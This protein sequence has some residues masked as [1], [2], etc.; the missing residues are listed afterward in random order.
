MWIKS[1]QDTLKFCTMSTWR[2]AV[3]SLFFLQVSLP[4]LAGLL[5]LLDTLPP[6]PICWIG[7]GSRGCWCREFTMPSKNT[8]QGAKTWSLCGDSSGV[9]ITVNSFVYASIYFS[10]SASNCKNVKN[11]NLMLFQL[12][13]YI[14]ASIDRLISNI[15]MPSVSLPLFSHIFNTHLF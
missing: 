13:T 12:Y 8:W 2:S 6:W 3:L 5:T 7:Q 15:I 1:V 10:D 11:S 9:S 14:D 4:V